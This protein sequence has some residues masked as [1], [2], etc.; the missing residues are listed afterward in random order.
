MQ[1]IYRKTEEGHMPYNHFYVWTGDTFVV[2]IQTSSEGTRL[3]IW[4]PSQGKVPD[5]PLISVL[6]DATRSSPLRM[7][8]C[9]G[10]RTMLFED[11]LAVTN[12]WEYYLGIIESI[13]KLFIEPLNNGAFDF[14]ASEIAYSNQDELARYQVIINRNR[15]DDLRSER[16]AS[17]YIITAP[18]TIDVESEENWHDFLR[19]VVHEFLSTP[20][21]RIAWED[22]HEDF[23]WGDVETYIPS[24]FLAQHGIRE[25]HDND[26]LD[27]SG[28]VI[29]EVDQDELFD[30]PEKEET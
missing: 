25:Y 30:G 5:I 17:V 22:T 19:S 11:A 8:I 13:Q 29:L 18:E 15:Q 6:G 21:G 26:P 4:S 14:E 9:P 12:A 1:Q 20:E 3:Y 28:T 2:R 27:V 10:R 7:E 23:N 24:N 16:Y